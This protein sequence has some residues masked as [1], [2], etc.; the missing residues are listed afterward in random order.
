MIT[1]VETQLEALKALKSDDSIRK[2]LV[3]KYAQVPTLTAPVGG[4]P[5]AP[6]VMTLQK[7]QGMGGKQ[8]TEMEVG[9]IFAKYYG[10]AKL[11]EEIQDPANKALK[12]ANIPAKLGADVVT[13]AKA[14]K[15]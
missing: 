6:K 5:G 3:D 11:A 4:L 13:A 2:K 8:G 7:I 12:F 1:S 10:L 9:A 15:D 14:T